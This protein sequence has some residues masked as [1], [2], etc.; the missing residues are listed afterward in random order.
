MKNAIVFVVGAACG[1]LLT[2][3]L[4]EKKFKDLADEEIQSVIDTFKK[5]DDELQVKE[6][7]VEVDEIDNTIRKYEHKVAD[8][9]Y[10]T[11]I[12]N[13]TVKVDNGPDGVEPYVISPE[14]YGELD[15][16][17]IVSWMYYEDGVLTNEMDEIVEDPELV[18]GNALDHFGDYTEDA[19]YVRSENDK[20]DYEILRSEQNFNGD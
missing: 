4:V 14:E 20:C 10:S 8:L 5:K 9:G 1:S 12:D 7:Y 13:Y 6:S 2:Y 19:V 15:G 17:N 11:D 3:K 18:I 16:Y